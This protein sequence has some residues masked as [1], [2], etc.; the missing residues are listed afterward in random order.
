MFNVAGAFAEV[1]LS[2]GA[3]AAAK[4]VGRSVS[5]TG[6]T[7]GSATGGYVSAASTGAAHATAEIIGSSVSVTGGTITGSVMGGYVSAI[8]HTGAAHATARG[9]MVRLSG[10]NY[11]G[12]IFGDNAKSESGTGTKTVIA[13]NNTVYITGGSYDTTKTIYGGYAKTA[14]TDNAIAATIQS[15]SQTSRGFPCQTSRADLPT[16]H[17][18]STRAIHSFCAMQKTS[19]HQVCQPSR[20][21]PSMFR[22]ICVRAT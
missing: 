11:R 18:P 20:S 17:P 22:R 19:Q 21:T 4:V 15:R 8:S 7:I 6:G 5:V 1:S 10:G 2:G 14:P 13:E 9:N 3:R 12:N 16:V